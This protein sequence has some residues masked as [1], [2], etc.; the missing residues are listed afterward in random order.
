VL[1]VKIRYNNRKVLAGIAE[2]AGV[3][4]QMMTMTI[5]V[6]KLDKIGWEGVRK[7]LDNRG[8]TATSIDTI[9]QL[10]SAD[11]DQLTSALSASEIGQKG[12]N[13][14][15][16]VEEFLSLADL[17]NDVSFDVDLARGLNY[18]TGCIFEV[19]AI[20][21]QIGSIGGGGRYDDLTSVFGLPNV[22]GVGISFGAER[23]YDVLEEKSLFPDSVK[24]DLD[25]LLCPMDEAAVSYS[26]SL[27]QKL[28]SKGLSVDMYPEPAKLKKQLKYVHT[29]SIPFAGIIGSQE[30]EQGIVQIKDMEEGNQSNLSMDEIIAQF[31][32]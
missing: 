23:I 32:G 29:R 11:R 14:L 6:D 10:F 17:S 1:P 12:L 31:A 4:D 20:D 5:S 30:M 27:L 3:S 25:L 24:T 26:F 19:N 21:A 28:R 18:Y 22:S 8:F 13:E 7:D 15:A 16:D 2:V 9:Q